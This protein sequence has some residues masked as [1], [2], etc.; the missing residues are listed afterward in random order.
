MFSIESNTRRGLPRTLLQSEI[1]ERRLAV[2]ET[3]FFES[4]KH[5]NGRDKLV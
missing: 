5:D 1:S 2:V 4:R 3:D